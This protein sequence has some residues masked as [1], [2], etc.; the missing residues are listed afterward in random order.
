MSELDALYQEII[1]DHRKAPRNFGPLAGSNVTQ[2]GYNPLCGD[3]VVLELDVEGGKLKGCGFQGEGCA[4]CMAS[5]SL[6]TEEVKGYTVP[7]ALA[8]VQDFRDLMMGK[9]EPD[10]SGDR[11]VEALAGVRRF[12]VRIKCALLPWTTLREALEK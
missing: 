3:R 12:P 5:A 1:Q 6:M 2:E 11:E 8:A 7:E 10:E 4:I 9:R